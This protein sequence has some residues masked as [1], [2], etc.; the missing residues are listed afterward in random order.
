MRLVRPENAQKVV[1]HER[2]WS[3]DF[4]DLYLD[5]CEELAIDLPR[6]AYAMGRHAPML[7]QRIRVGTAPE[8]Y[9]TG[10]ARWE[11]VI[12]ATAVYASCCRVAGELTEARFALDK[13]R[14]LLAEARDRR[15]EIGL[16]ID[17]ELDRREA[18]YWATRGDLDAAEALV[19][20][21]LLN[22]RKVRDEP[23]LASVYSLR[24]LLGQLSTRGT[25]VS[26]FSEAMARA[27]IQTNRGRRTFFAALHNLTIAAATDTH[28]IDA[29]KTAYLLLET[30]KSTLA[31][32]PKSIAK[33]KVFWVEGLLM[34]RFG[35]NRH[36][37]R[38]LQ[39]ARLGLLAL[40]DR[41]GFFAASIDLALIDQ[42]HGDG[43]SAQAVIDDCLRRADAEDLEQLAAR[44]WPQWLILDPA[45]LRE[46]R[47]R[48]AAQP[49]Q[50]A[51]Q[52]WL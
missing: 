19:G 31:R 32:R 30:V 40:G 6:D 49:V 28:S 42:A 21:A 50:T 38:K 12:Y 13:A 10:Q 27:D 26:D 46:T 2:Y 17:A 3:V 18:A 1:G 52:R 25:N 8:E 45:K 15:V 44:Q 22:A 16:R 23:N 29:C 51:K 24:G 47:G 11:S 14:E 37:E 36:A 43:R 39:K 20:R 7:A 4:L 48:L 9:P 5:Q 33:L 41:S 34:A 35:L